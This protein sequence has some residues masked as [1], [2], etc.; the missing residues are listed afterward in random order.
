VSS[1][2]TT[3]RHLAVRRQR[4][5]AESELLDDAPADAF[6]LS[7]KRLE[8]LERRGEM[9]VASAGA[10]NGVRLAGR[11]ATLVAAIASSLSSIMGA[12]I[13]NVDLFDLGSALGGVLAAGALLADVDDASA[14]ASILLSVAGAACG[15]GRGSLPAAVTVPGSLTGG[16]RFGTAA[17][18]T[19]AAA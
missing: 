13:A 12:D 2:S 19:T 7:D 16:L 17:S 14:T 4:A 11:L 18:G 1:A 8:P 9:A 15:N 6:T 10:Q 5:T 3:G